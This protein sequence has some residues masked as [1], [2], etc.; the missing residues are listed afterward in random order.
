MQL[1]W[2]REVL[3]PATQGGHLFAAPWRGFISD[4]TFP[5]RLNVLECCERPPPPPW[6]FWKLMKPA[7]GGRTCLPR[8]CL[9]SRLWS[10]G[11][12]ASDVNFYLT[13][14]CSD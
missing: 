1:C 12:M 6:Q 2:S 3:Q 8:A 7:T 10:R 13:L 4:S 5:V 14:S 9:Y 11:R